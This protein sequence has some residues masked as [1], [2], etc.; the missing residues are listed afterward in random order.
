MSD[1]TDAPARS[2]SSGRAYSLIWFLLA[3]VVYRGCAVGALEREE[4]RESWRPAEAVVVENRVGYGGLGDDR[5]YLHAVF[6]VGEGAEARTSE[7][8]VASGPLRSVERR[9]AEEFAPGTRHAVFVDPANPG[10]LMF[11][12]DAGRQYWV[13]VAGAALFAALGLSVLL[14][15]RRPAADPSPDRS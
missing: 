5:Y 9:A 7:E 4:L 3:F 1:T 8:Q 12:E 11:P 15:P 13:G 14:S 2:S 10:R 6:S